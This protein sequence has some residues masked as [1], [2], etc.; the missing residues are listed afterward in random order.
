MKF[1]KDKVILTA[2]TVAALAN[3]AEGQDKITSG[4][5]LDHS[6]TPV[7]ITAED[8]QLG[9]K[10]SVNN[11]ENMNGFMEKFNQL[12]A[13]NASLKQEIDKLKNSE[14]KKQK[15]ETNGLE[16]SFFKNSST[17]EYHED[18][19]FLINLPENLPVPKNVVEVTKSKNMSF[20]EIIG[21]HEILPIEEAF[22]QAIQLIKNKKEGV[23][24]FKDE[25]GAFW[26]ISTWTNSARYRFVVLV[27]QEKDLSD[28]WG[29]HD[30]HFYFSK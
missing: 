23:V 1:S 11:P 12:K 6:P 20:K 10:D 19:S 26:R 9:L 21:E 25:N 8:P 17:M 2:A 3:V 22:G 14:N 7:N 30:S 24:F 16:K 27:T 29:P 5:N 18:K 28:K 4:S 15:I 13:E